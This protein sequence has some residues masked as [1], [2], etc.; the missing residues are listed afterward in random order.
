MKHIKFDVV[1][2]VAASHEDPKNPGVLKKVL[3]RREDL[4]EGRVQMIN[5]AFLPAGKSFRLHYHEDMQ[6]L[7]IMMGEGAI[8]VI[9]KEEIPLD[10]GDVLVVDPGESHEMKNPTATQIEYIVVGIAGESK[11]KSVNI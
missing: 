7:F 11:G 9:N 8:A 2:T 1:P 6:E 3:F 4:F 10:Y 5:W